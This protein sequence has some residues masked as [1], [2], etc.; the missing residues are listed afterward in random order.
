MGE[1]AS[2]SQGMRAGAGGRHLG[3]ERE[4]RT[5]TLDMLSFHCTAFP[6]TDTEPYQRRDSQGLKLYQGLHRLLAV[7]LESKT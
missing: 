1:K 7:M 6:R 4:N 3:N 5:E 2:D